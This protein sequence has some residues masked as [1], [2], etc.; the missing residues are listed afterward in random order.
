MRRMHRRT[1]GGRSA[2]KGGGS[3]VRGGEG[4]GSI[5]CDT[6]S[7]MV[8]PARGRDGRARWG[9]GGRSLWWG[10]VEDVHGAAALFAWGTTTTKTLPPTA[11]PIRRRR[12]AR[13][14]HVTRRR[15]SHLFP[16]RGSKK[17]SRRGEWKGQRTHTK[18]DTRWLKRT[19]I[20]LLLAMRR[21]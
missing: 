15:E 14:G 17:G 12:K 13:V 19:V 7:C 11:F 5:A 21:W 1:R 2:T 18:W 10:M 6:P 20:L 16:R 8:S 3:H 4:W 9:W